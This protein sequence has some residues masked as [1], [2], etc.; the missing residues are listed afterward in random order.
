MQTSAKFLARAS[1][2]IGL[3]ACNG[4]GA[5]F[6]RSRFSNRGRFRVFDDV[7]ANSAFRFDGKSDVFG[8]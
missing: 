6:E 3:H 5:L 7:V 1:R 2:A 4:N 8:G